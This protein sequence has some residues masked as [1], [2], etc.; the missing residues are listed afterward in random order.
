[1]S[2]YS[3]IALFAFLR[4]EKTKLLLDDLQ[5]DPVFQSSNL[6]IFLDYPK[7]PEQKG[8]WRTIHDFLLL[9][10]EKNQ[11]V[12]LKVREKNFGL[13]K[14]II[15][16]VSEILNVHNSCIVLE[17]DLRIQP[18]F[19]TY[20]NGAL[21][22]Y[23]KQKNVGS[24]T[25]HNS[26]Q[27]P[28][29]ANVDSYLSPRHSSWGWGTWAEVWQAVDWKPI[30]FQSERS[31]FP[32]HKFFTLGGF[33]LPKMLRLQSE[34]KINSWSI[35]FDY[36][37]WKQGLHCVTATKSLVNHTGLDE[38]ATHH[39][40]SDNREAVERNLS[41]LKTNQDEIPTFR[42]DRVEVSKKIFK[43]VR[44]HYNIRYLLV[45]LKHLT[46]LITLRKKNR[47]E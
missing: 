25:A 43:D 41:D 34:G 14:N 19:L 45:L 15:S 36:H 44:R 21:K 32:K 5:A 11:N 35:Q 2:S 42:W 17:D 26:V 23:K 38:I 27:S 18:F 33:D 6:Y 1:M 47:H 37:C 16:G 31:N 13:R 24:V 20:M 28:Q 3:P 29:L 30:N 22:H 7:S 40:I 9:I 46:T 12:T 10:E 8:K 4:L 39:S